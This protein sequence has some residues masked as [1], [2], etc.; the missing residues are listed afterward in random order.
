[1]M[2]YPFY[3]SHETALSA[4]RLMDTAGSRSAV[5]VGTA[6]SRSVVWSWVVT[7]ERSNQ[8][9]VQGEML[10]LKEVLMW[11]KLHLQLKDICAPLWDIGNA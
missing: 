10:I 1:M 4:Q 11:G 5:S 8:F 7:G 9:L 6:G 3:S 2:E